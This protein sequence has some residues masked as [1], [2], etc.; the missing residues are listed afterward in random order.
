[1][2]KI[3]D[4]KNLILALAEMPET[5]ESEAIKM[6]IPGKSEYVKA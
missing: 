6:C 1:M 3:I 2:P 4:V 5:N